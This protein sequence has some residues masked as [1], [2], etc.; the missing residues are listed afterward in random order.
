[1]RLLLTLALGLTACSS[2]DATTRE[3]V[4]VC[5][6]TETTAEVEA[7]RLTGLD[8][9]CD[10]TSKGTQCDR[11]WLRNAKKYNY[12]CECNKRPQCVTEL[13]SWNE[14]LAV[15]RAMVECKKPSCSC[16]S[17]KHCGSSE[18]SRDRLFRCECP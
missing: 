3:T 15:G 12:T 7:I 14:G 13:C 10:C 5:A 4:S 11:T 9:S 8:A 16:Y 18:T 17:L 1:M 6:V 2:S